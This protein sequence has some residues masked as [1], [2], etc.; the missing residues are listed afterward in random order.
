MKAPP[1]LILSNFRPLEYHIFVSLQVN[2]VRFYL[3]RFV[4]ATST[5][6]RTPGLS[7]VSLQIYGVKPMLNRYATI[8]AIFV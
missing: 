8:L 2:F 1:T 6:S 4:E 5:Q 3:A 7:N